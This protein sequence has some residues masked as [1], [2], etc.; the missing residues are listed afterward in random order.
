M[1]FFNR[2]GNDLYTG[3]LSFPFVARRKLWFIIA[4]ILVI[5]AALVPLVRPIQFSI[6]FTGGS[7]FTVN[8]VAPPIDQLQ[9]TDAVQT[10]VP[11]ATTKV[12]TIGDDAVR[13]QRGGAAQHL[14][15]QHLE[16]EHVRVH[17]G[18][19]KQRLRVAHAQQ[20]GHR[21]G[22]VRELRPAAR[23]QR[24]LAGAA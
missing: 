10:V 21:V 7:Q 2:F 8:N 22:A 3:K 6:E 12:V 1:R 18:A 17:D 15:H 13:V 11:S 9:A 5:A 23:L 19:G 24:R 16:A 20:P 14:H 4:A